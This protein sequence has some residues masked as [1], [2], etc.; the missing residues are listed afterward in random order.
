M[1][2]GERRV[3]LNKSRR[4]TDNTDTAAQ[5]EA[6]YNK[7]VNARRHLDMPGEEYKLIVKKALFT[8][9]EK[10]LCYSAEELSK[11]VDEPISKLRPIM[12]EIL[13]Y[14]KSGPF[15]GKYELKDEY[16]TT[17]QREQKVQE[18][19]DHRLAEIEDVK[20]RREEAKQN[21][22]DRAEPALKKSRF[23]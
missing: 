16:K 3:A 4:V 13:T 7:K 22:L 18:L 9:F 6:K 11:A 21:E 19:E 23:N 14:N 20:R 5:K 17:Q 12:N 2:E 1:D 10:T 8:A 15:N